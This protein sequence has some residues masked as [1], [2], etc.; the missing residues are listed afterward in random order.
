MVA[1]SSPQPARELI[2]KCLKQRISLIIVILAL[3][4]SYIGEPDTDKCEK[5]FALDSQLLPQ[6]QIPLI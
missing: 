5:G 3:E 2:K 4:R 6:R 1:A